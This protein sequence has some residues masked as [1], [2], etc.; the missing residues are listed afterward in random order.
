MPKTSDRCPWWICWHHRRLRRA[1]LWFLAIIMK[2]ARTI[3]LAMEAW[4]LF[5]D[6]DGQEHWRCPCGRRHREEIAA[7]AGVLE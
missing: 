3:E 4:R 2:K 6:G 7:T 1:D 5:L